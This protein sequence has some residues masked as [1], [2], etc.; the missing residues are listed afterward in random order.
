MRGMKHIFIF[1]CITIISPVYGQHVLNVKDLGAKADGQHDDYLVIQKAIDGAIQNPSLGTSIYFP[2]GRYRITHP[3]LLQYVVNGR[4]QFFTIKLFGDAPAKSASNAY[5]S[6]I[7]CDFTDGFAIGIQLG[8]GVQIENLN[9]LG[10]YTFPLSMTN[11][12]I[13]TTL[14][15]EWNNGSVHDTRYAPYSGIAIDPFC[16][17]NDL[18]AADG[19]NFLRNE[20]LPGTGRGG[21][22]G[23]EIRQCAIH[24]FAVGIAMTPNPLTANDE[25][26]NIIDCD[27][28]DVKVAIAIGQDQ[29]KEIHID[30]FKCW[31][32]AH[33]ILDGLHYGRGTGGGSVMINGMNI[34]GNVN[35]LFELVADRFPLSAKDIYSESLFRIGLVGSGAGANF[36]NFQIDFLTGKGMPAPDYIFAGGPATFTGGML[37]YYDG[38]ST[39][40]MNLST[41]HVVFRDMTLSTP[42]II[43]NLYGKGLSSYSAPSFENVHLYYGPGYGGTLG[44]NRTFDYPYFFSNGTDPL[45]H[46]SQ[47]AFNSGTGISYHILETEDYEEAVRLPGNLNIKIDRTKWTGSF[48]GG[49]GITQLIHPGDYLIASTNRTYY[50]HDINGGDCPTVQIGRVA[51]IHKDSVYLDDIGLNTYTGLYTAYLDIVYYTQDGLIFNCLKGSNVMTSVQAISLNRA[52]YGPGTRFTTNLFPKCAY[53]VNYDPKAGTITMSAP[54]LA[55]ANDVSLINGNPDVTMTSDMPPGY[56]IGNSPYKIYG[57][58][59]GI[60]KQGNLRFQIESILPYGDTTLHKF[61]YLKVQ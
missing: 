41:M 3:L 22:S 24:Q 7:I 14:Y 31:G 45:Y 17:S 38:N 26:I 16:D 35:Q 50:D 21:T 42:P 53:V 10:R 47:Y 54:A 33:T 11:K 44:I 12:N 5:L 15:S 8:R 43:T 6:S 20:Y 2:V 18:K 29:S 49:P 52:G 48:L 57:L 56:W 1:I 39:H 13:G 36:I 34:A 25:M 32:S 4:W 58:Y 59:P 40:R 46:G 23:V 37:R 28:E 27:V 60:Y 51:S 19:Y 55:T 9:F 61:H 30:R